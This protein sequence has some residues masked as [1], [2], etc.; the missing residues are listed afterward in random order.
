MKKVTY[1]FSVAVFNDMLYWSDAK[2]RIVQAATKLSGKNRQI[3]LKRPG[4]PV[5]LKVKS[6]HNI[7]LVK[8]Q[9]FDNF[10]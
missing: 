9:I 3:V 10:L 5:A 1:P 6:R 2:Q 7:V 4:Q 8:V